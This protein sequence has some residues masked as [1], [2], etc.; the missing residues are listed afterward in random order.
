MGKKVNDEIDPEAYVLVELEKGG[1][2]VNVKG[3]QIIL[4]SAYEKIK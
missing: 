4:L 3:K 2:E 1:S